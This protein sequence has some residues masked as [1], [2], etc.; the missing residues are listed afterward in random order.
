[1][2]NRRRYRPC[3][4]KANVQRKSNTLYKKC[5]TTM[6]DL[7]KPKYTNEG[8]TTRDFSNV[9]RDAWRIVHAHSARWAFV[10]Q[11]YIIFFF[12]FFGRRFIRWDPIWTSRM[13]WGWVNYQELFI[14]EVNCSFNIRVC[15]TRF[16]HKRFCRAGFRKLEDQN[17][18][19][20]KVEFF[21]FWIEHTG[22]GEDNTNDNILNITSNQVFI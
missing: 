12:F 17:D 2:W 22:N 5:K 14:L 20:W 18:E 7:F 11:R 15:R 9:I 1:M 10:N 13:T 8:L 19:W 4:Y 21:S 16:D 6:S 3:V